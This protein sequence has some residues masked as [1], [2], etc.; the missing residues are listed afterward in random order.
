MPIEFSDRAL[1]RLPI[2]FDAETLVAEVKALP[3]EAWVPHPNQF[4]GNDAVRLITTNGQ[5]TDA[6]DGAQAPTPYLDACPYIKELMGELGATWGRSR[7][8]GL[9]AGAQVPPHVDSHYYWRT[10]I[11]IHIPVI[12]NPGVAF[13]CGDEEVNMKPGECWV[14]D[15]FRRHEV[16]NRGTEHRV[17]LVIDTVGGGRMWELVKRAQDDPDAEPELF[18]PGSGGSKPLLFEQMNS[19]PVMSPWEIRCHVDLLRR[20]ALP[21]PALSAVLDRLEQLIQEWGG[22]WSAFGA[23]PSGLPEYRRLLIETGRDLGQLR[24]ETIMLSNQLPLY[25]VLERLVFEVAIDPAVMSGAAQQR[26]AS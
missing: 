17:H 25:H 21:H 15:S 4:P 12:T 9:A 11:R 24:G 20:M 1:L 7:L 5:P 10:H 14:F 8:M 19:P 13:I 2:R 3:R 18:A 16:H 22:I 23:S 26:L 6:L